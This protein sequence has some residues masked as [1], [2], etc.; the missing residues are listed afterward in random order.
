V[1]TL[2]ALIA[3]AVSAAAS[4][5]T[6]LRIAVWPEGRAN[7]DALVWRL[8]C[9][10]AGGTLPE[11]RAA[12]RRLFAMERPF[13]PVPKDVACTQI[14]GGPQEAIVAGTFRARRIWAR[15]RRNDGCQIARWNRHAFLFPGSGAGG[16]AARRG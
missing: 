4:P 2:A 8:R 16:S 7:G 3:A 13:A 10:P 9:N 6:D 11:P 12:C 1:T 5:G 15:F 14:Y